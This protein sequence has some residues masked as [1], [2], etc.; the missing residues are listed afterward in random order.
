MVGTGFRGQGKISTKNGCAKL[1]DQLFLGIA[2]VT[3]LLTAKV[4]V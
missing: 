4:A 3:Q 2:R 1:C